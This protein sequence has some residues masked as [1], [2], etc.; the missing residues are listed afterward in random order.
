M[1][2][3]LSKA[4][5]QIEKIKHYYDNAGSS[6]YNAAV[7]HWNELSSLVRRAL[8]SKHDKNDAAI[9]QALGESVKMMMDEMEKRR[10]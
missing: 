3:Y 10:D 2:K 6:G 7:Y 1:G 5:E 9:I 4:Y 8:D